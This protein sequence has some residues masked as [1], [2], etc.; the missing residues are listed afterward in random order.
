MAGVSEYSDLDAFYTEEE[1][2]PR[3]ARSGEVDFGWWHDPE[4][5][6]DGRPIGVSSSLDC[7]VS[8]VM[9][10]GEVYVYRARPYGRGARVE[11]LG[12]VKARDQLERLLEGWEH[13]AGKITS[14]G[15]SWVKQRLSALGSVPVIRSRLA[16]SRDPEQTEARWRAREEEGTLE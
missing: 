9:E 4:L 13:E 14:V 1:V 7:R 3:R 11:V 5:G 15:V 12:V 8:W 10:T 6:H 2:G 16:D